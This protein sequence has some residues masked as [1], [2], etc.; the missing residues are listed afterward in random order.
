MT[1]TLI[2]GFAGVVRDAD[3]A[4]IPDD[5]NNIDWQ[6]YLTWLSVGNKPTPAPNAPVGV[7]VE[8]TR[9]QFFQAAAQQGLIPQ[10]AALALL[11]T[12]TIPASLTAA[13]FSLPESEQFAAQ[14]AILGDPIFSRADPF[15]AA[16]GA[17]MGQTSSQIDALF[18]LA[19]TL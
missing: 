19:A 10:S 9:R 17:A 8:I 16:L 4:T 12:G 14:M 7:P 18:T 6:A 11:A 3:R 5:P 15:I 2:S 1:Y 13:I